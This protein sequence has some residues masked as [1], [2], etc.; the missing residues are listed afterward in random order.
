MDL[1]NIEDDWYCR[2]WVVRSLDAHIVEIVD[3]L[4]SSSPRHWSD[5]TKLL[6]YLEEW[7]DL[8]ELTGD[9]MLWIIKQVKYFTN[10][11]EEDI[12]EIK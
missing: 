3:D 5:V 1:H 4:I 12:Q 9:E 11:M 2:E 6:G 10:L 7:F 8:K